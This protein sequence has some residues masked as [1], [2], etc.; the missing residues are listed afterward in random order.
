MKVEENDRAVHG[1][2][3][4]EHRRCKDILQSLLD[5]MK[6]YPKGSLN[7]RKKYYKDNVYHY[8]Y[9]VS[10]EG[11]AVVNRHVPEEKLPLVREHMKQREKYQKEIQSYRKRIAYLERL[12]KI[13]KLQRSRDKH[14]S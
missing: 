5:K 14:S 10:R 7:V 1:L 9:L 8:H 4:E 3:E 6:E 11:G 12:L 13:P 2:L